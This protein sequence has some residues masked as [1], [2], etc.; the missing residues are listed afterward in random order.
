M[1]LADDPLTLAEM[2]RKGDHEGAEDYRLGVSVKRVGGRAYYTHAG[3]WGTAVY[4]S[5]DAGVSIA[6]FTTH[7]AERPALVALIEESISAVAD[8]MDPWADI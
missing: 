4:Y 6:G 1:R 3:F 8:G 7:R 5:P 2:L